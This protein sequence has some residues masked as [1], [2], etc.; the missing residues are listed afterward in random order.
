MKNLDENRGSDAEF[1]ILTFCQFPDLP[2]AFCESHT[3]KCVA[4]GA[5][6]HERTPKP[7]FS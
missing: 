1:S 4:F 6:M 5:N 2:I 3:H 7:N